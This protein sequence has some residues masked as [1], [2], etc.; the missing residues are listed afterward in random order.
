M[1]LVPLIDDEAAAPDVR[2]VYADIRATRQSDFINNFWRALANDPAELKRTWERT[3]EVMAP[4]ALDPVA[5]ELVYLAVSITNGCEYC[6]CSHRAAAIAKGMS[7][8]MFMELV[9]V[10]A[11]ANANNR[12]ATALQVDV[13]ERFR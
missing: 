10:V 9:A 13:D 12:L 4:G 1:A 2:A 5:K 11:L 6:I 7:E 3:R 8:A